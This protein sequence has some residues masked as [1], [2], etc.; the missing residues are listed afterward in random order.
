[1]FNKRLKW[2]FY[3]ATPLIA[4]LPF[5]G[6]VN[7][8]KVF[9]KIILHPQKTGITTLNLYDE[10]R[11]RL[12]PTEIW[13]PIDP[14]IPARA[15][16]G[17]WVRCDEARDA[18]LSHKQTRYPLIVIS[19]G[20]G[21]DRFNISWL[22]EV[23]AANGYIVAAM[24]HFGNTWNNKIPEC[25]AKPWERPKDVTFVL[26]H[27][28]SDSPFKD[29]IDTHRIGFAGYS[30][31][32]ATGIWIAGAKA[33]ETDIDQMK[34]FCSQ[35]LSEIVTPEVVEA[36]N[37]R[38]ACCSFFDPRFSSMFVM[39]PALGWLFEETSLKNIQIPI[40]IIAPEK[41]QIVPVEKNAK[42]LAKSIASSSLMILNGEATHFVFLNRAT[43]MGKR[44][45]DSK[46]C[47]DPT[48]IDRKKIH[49]TLAKKAVEFFSNQTPQP[50][51]SPN[52]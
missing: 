49:Q 9:K 26:D 45:L 20:S 10:T 41:D 1:M 12:L 43:V 13:Y 23:L 2:L 21:G 47:E 4:F 11:D 5:T 33:N 29:K 19:H 34:S 16:S 42:I 32:G 30:L 28:L 37:F 36:V 52:L 39:A 7:V 8:T 17:V 22:A 38:E 18:P 6:I 48:S 51:S 35:E 31:G 46:Y 24:D 44:F 27:L 3:L 50:K 40:Y 14:H 15:S 25:Y